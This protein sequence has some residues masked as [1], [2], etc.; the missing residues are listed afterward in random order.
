[1]AIGFWTAWCRVSLQGW[2]GFKSYKNCEAPG[3]KGI[4]E[5]KFFQSFFLVT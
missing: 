1:M 3:Q 2:I 4:R 5:Q